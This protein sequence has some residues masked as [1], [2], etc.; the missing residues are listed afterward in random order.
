MG[1]TPPY[2]YVKKVAGAYKIYPPSDQVTDKLYIYP[3]LP[4]TD[5]YICIDPPTRIELVSQGGIR[6]SASWGVGLLDIS[7]SGNDNI[8]ETTANKN[9]WLKPDGTGKIKFGTTTA[10]G[11]VAC[12]GHHDI[13]DNA[14]NLVKLMTTA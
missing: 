6:I 1:Y 5:H 9:I 4:S 10:T 11:D 14:G 2:L 3:N 13:L 8:I 12:N 7:A